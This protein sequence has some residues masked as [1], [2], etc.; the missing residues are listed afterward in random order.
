MSL[1][2]PSSDLPAGWVA[3]DGLLTPDVSISGYL[4]RGQEVKGV[5]DQRDCRR[6]C[7]I[8][9]P[10]LAARGF[11][12]LPLTTVQGFLRC[13]SLA[14]CGLDFHED[15][16]AG[17]PLRALLGRSHVKIRIKC[18]G[19]GFFRVTRVEGLIAKLSAT[20]P[21]ADSLMTSEVPSQITG[22]CKT[23][24]KSAW[25]VDVL[26]PALNSEGQR[27]TSP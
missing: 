3:Q 22:P 19:C 18:A 26:W 8:D 13:H 6:R 11:G 2:A 14:G 24:K 4:A 5:C 9:L 15:P 25:R 27:R 1:P 10:R 20:R 12:A 16:K 21:M 7:Q 17:L 23:C